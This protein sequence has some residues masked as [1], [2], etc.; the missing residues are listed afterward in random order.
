MIR[1]LRRAHSRN[2]FELK[3]LLTDTKGAPV[4][5]AVLDMVAEPLEISGRVVREGTQYY[6]Q[7][8]PLTYRRV[9]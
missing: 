2:A 6:F 7:A 9:R 1:S 4:N 3:L 8:D 5:Q